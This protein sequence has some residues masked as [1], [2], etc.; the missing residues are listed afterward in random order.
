ME[1]RAAESFRRIAGACIEVEI[2]ADHEY[3]LLGIS[4]TIHRD[5]VQLAQPKAVGPSA[6]EVKIVSDNLTAVD[7]CFRYEGN[8]A[9]IRRDSHQ[10]WELRAGSKVKYE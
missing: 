7:G 2:A 10:P 6:L 9:A 1:A 5:F 8:S 3:R 4:T